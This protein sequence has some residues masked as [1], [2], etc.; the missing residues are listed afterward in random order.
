ML[1]YISWMEIPLWNEKLREFIKQY[2][3]AVMCLWPVYGLMIE[4]GVRYIL[5]CN[6]RSKN[7]N[8]L[9]VW[10]TV[11]DLIDIGFSVYF[12]AY[13]LNLLIEFSHGYNGFDTDS[14]IIVGVVFYV[15]FAFVTW[16]YI[17]NYAKCYNYNRKFTYYMIVMERQFMMMRMWYIK[18]NTSSMQ[19]EGYMCNR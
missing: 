1:K 18:E 15:F 10:C 7:S 12:L 3:F 4:R 13:G 11:D 6:E 8:W 9:P 14:K 2:M 5:I 19:D 17:Q 16:L